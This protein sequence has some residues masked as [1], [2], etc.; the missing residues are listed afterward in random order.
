MAYFVI[1]KLGA[2]SLMLNMVF[3][4]RSTHGPS[5]YN[6]IYLQAIYK[7]DLPLPTNSVFEAIKCNVRPN[8]ISSDTN[9]IRDIMPDC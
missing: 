8:F 5:W 9:L 1:F 6:L 2:N 3:E 7:L 4:T